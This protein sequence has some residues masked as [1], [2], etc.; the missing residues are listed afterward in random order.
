[1]FLH[2]SLVFLTL[3]IFEKNDEKLFTIL[4]TNNKKLFKEYV[5]WQYEIKDIFIVWSTVIG[6]RYNL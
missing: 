1:M 4:K 6:N 5:F 3:Y 2:I